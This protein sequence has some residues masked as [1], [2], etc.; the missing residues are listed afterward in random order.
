MSEH[1]EGIG[2]HFNVI[3]TSP[4][5][6]E[7]SLHHKNLMKEVNE[8]VNDHILYRAPGIINAE[9]ALI[10]YMAL[11]LDTKPGRSKF[12][13][14][15]LHSITW[16]AMANY[17]AQEPKAKIKHR[18]AKSEPIIKFLN[19]AVANA[20]RGDGDMRPPSLFVWYQQSFDQILFGVGF[21][22]LT[23]LVQ[24]RLI[25][26]K[27]DSGKWK[28]KKCVV[29]D[30]LWDEQLS[31]FHT[32]VSRDALPG[33][34]G[35]TSAHNDKF[36]R[37]E[38]FAKFF[39][40]NPNYFNV[41]LAM[42]KFK[43][44]FI[45][46]RRY[47]NLPGDLYFVQAMDADDDMANEMVEGIPIREDYILEYGPSHRPRKMI[48]ISSIHGEFNF[49]MKTGE[50]PALV[51]DGRQY[52]EM[53]RPLH[54][55]TFWTKG[56]GQ[57]AKGCIGLKRSLWRTTHDNMKASSVFFAMSQN[58]GVLNQ[59]KRAD[60]YGIV[61]MKADE[62][63]FNVKALLERNQV[64]AGVTEYDEA[65]ENICAG[66]LGD[67]WRQSAAQLTSEKATVAA[68]R[69]QIKKV[70]SKQK[71]SM[72]EVGGYYRHKL[73]QINLIQQ[74]YPEKTEIDLSDDEELPQDIEETD[75]IRDSDG[76]PIGYRREKKIAYDEP[77]VVERKNG[78]LDV[79]VDAV[80]G[81]RLI[82]ATKDLIVTEE[83]PEI[84]IEPYSAGA[85]NEAIDRALDLERLQHYQF[86]LGLAYPNPATGQ[87]ETLISRE[88]AQHL[89]K[90]SAEVWNDDPDEL[91][92][93]KEKEEKPKMRRPYSAP[94]RPNAPTP[95]VPP[96]Q[97]EFSGAAQGS[98]MGALTSPANT[99]ARALTPGA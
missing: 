48:P 13:P 83:E 60:L 42:E 98:A 12:F 7:I 51:Q 4:A 74:F 3:K 99:L 10:G 97:T 50:T 68:I 53:I 45:R 25:H 87:M 65:V 54:N 32:G 23:Y 16:S 61:P 21:R 96:V 94:P 63:S 46:V 82:P 5:L 92:G 58:P 34:Y 36:F 19:A 27:D 81:D 69:E 76:S 17:A 88:G 59:I 84:Y 71:Q 80:N 40:D 47:W 18:L 26:I 15:V 89:L 75:I 86:Y 78:I 44:E 33:M 8:D 66:A 20:E 35:T 24:K 1:T 90:K 9:E 37:R 14:P 67:D 70:R 73:L 79:Q 57:I 43:G 22:H 6:G 93:N 29:Y 55:H 38:S 41:K 91:V 11:S 2:K 28:E 31:F 72:N 95:S 49:D 85:E 64:F 62:R 77:V 39:L 56:V 30:D 52:N